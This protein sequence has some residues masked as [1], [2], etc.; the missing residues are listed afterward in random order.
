[1]SDPSSRARLAGP[2]VCTIVAKNYL[3]Y[4]RT[5][6]KSLRRSNPDLAAYVLFVDDIAGFVDPAAEAFPCLGL[7][8]LELP[9]PREFLLPLRRDGAVARR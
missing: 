1:M 4:A 2:A 7:D 5:L 3:A 8:D 6:V 9:R